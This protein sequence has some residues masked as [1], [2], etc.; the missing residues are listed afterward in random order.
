MAAFT[1]LC[2]KVN[3]SL[4]HNTLTIYSK[5]DKLYLPLDI[6]SSIN[7]I[8]RGVVRQDLEHNFCHDDTFDPE[9][10]HYH[11]EFPV[12][13]DSVKL[14]EILT[15]LVGE[16]HITN[17][18]KQ[19]FLADYAIAVD[20]TIDTFKKEL[21]KLEYKSEYFTKKAELNPAKY[22]EAAKNCVALYDA[23]SKAAA[24]YW[25]NK[26]LQTYEL[27]KK[28]AAEAIALAKPELAKHRG[29]KK[30]LINIAAAILGLGVIYL[31]A[32]SLNYVYTKGEHFFFHMNTDTLNIID[33]YTAAHSA[34]IR[35]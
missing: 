22:Q 23:L 27:F 17:T 31:F 2:S 28:K 14:S 18:E 24:N 1:H 10:I 3:I 15:I 12:T 11:L 29:C 8:P 20:G 19:R 16:G 13:I 25:T 4:A 21:K 6:F 32:A 33:N 7:A 34:L 35:Q 9:M 5:M 30:I 26:S